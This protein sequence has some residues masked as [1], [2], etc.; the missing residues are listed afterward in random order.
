ML[1]CRRTSS[2]PS[3]LLLWH[4]SCSSVFP[5]LEAFLHTVEGDTIRKVHA[6]KWL[7]EIRLG[8]S[9]LG[10]GQLLYAPASL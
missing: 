10:S 4:H 2:V 6:G 1:W 8:C 9:S 7:G 3:Q 5:H